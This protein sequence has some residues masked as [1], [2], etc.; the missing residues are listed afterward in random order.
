MTPDITKYKLRILF[1]L[2]YF[3][4]LTLKTV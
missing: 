4:G 1:Q 2:A 3:S